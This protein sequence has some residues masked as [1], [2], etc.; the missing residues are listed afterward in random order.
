[1][2]EGSMKPKYGTGLPAALSINQAST[3]V[4]IMST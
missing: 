1:M 3:G 4:A 2:G